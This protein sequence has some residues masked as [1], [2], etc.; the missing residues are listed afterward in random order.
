[1]TSQPDEELLA[2][3]AKGDL[4]SGSALFERHFEP[5]RRFFTNK[6]DR[7]VEE[8]VQTTFERLVAAASRFEGRSSFRT[9]LFSVAS[10]VLRDYYRRAR[11][12][13]TEELDDER[14]ERR[15]MAA[16][17]EGS[18][19]HALRQRDEE[20]ILLWALQHLSVDDQVAIFLYYWEDHTAQEL[21]HIYGV[22]EDTA[23]SRIRHAKSRLRKEIASAD[24]EHLWGYYGEDEDL[25]S[26]AESIR[27]RLRE[28]EGA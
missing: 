10:N 20:Q 26:W 14:L 21:G 9:F 18:P 7:D 19:E 22:G 6:V 3:W 16:P 17:G 25:W 8:L 24:S 15:P 27:S 28:R 13:R 5:I 1:M 4:S 23:R 12:R 11:L 2:R